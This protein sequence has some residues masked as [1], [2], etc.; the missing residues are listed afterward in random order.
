[1]WIICQANDS[2]EISGLVFFEKLKKIYFKMSSAAVVIG[3]LRVNIYVQN[4]GLQNK[5]ERK[6]K[7]DD[8]WIENER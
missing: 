6:K 8:E 5:N 4:Y 2:H 7:G 1:M 3:A